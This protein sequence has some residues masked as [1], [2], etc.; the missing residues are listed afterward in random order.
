MARKKAVVLTEEGKIANKVKDV[1]EGFKGTKIDSDG[2]GQGKTDYVGGSVTI[3]SSTDGSKHYVI[4]DCGVA[5]YINVNTSGVFTWEL[6][7]GGVA[8]NINGEYI[9]ER[10][11]KK[12]YIENGGKK[13]AMTNLIFNA[14]NYTT[15]VEE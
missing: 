5:K 15:P 14:N 13:Q 1:T 12:Y 11:G 3:Q 10:C 7:N 8:T 2:S 4:C 9:C 6:D